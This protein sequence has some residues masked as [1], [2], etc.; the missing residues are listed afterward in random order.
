[1]AHDGEDS[2]ESVQ[3][4]GGDAQATSG[5]AQANAICIGV[6]ARLCTFTELFTDAEAR[7]GDCNHD[8]QQS[9]TS[10]ACNVAV[11]LSGG[12]FGPFVTEHGYLRGNGRGQGGHNGCETD[13]DRNL[14]VRCC[15]DQAPTDDCTCTADQS[16]CRDGAGGDTNPYVRDVVVTGDCSTELEISE[17]ESV[18]IVGAAVTTNGQCW[19]HS[20]P[21]ALNVYDMSLGAVSNSVGNTVLFKNTDRR[22]ELLPNM[23]RQPANEGRARWSWPY[24]ASV[25]QDF[26]RRYANPAGSQGRAEWNSAGY[27]ILVGRLGD[28]VTFSKLPPLFQTAELAELV[29]AVVVGGGDYDGSEACGSPGEVANDATLGHNY[30]SRNVDA[31]SYAYQN[32]MAS[33]RIQHVAEGSYA[34]Y[35]M[36]VGAEDQLRQ[37][38][39]WALS[40]QFVISGDSFAGT[41]VLD[42]EHWVTYYDIF[43]RHAFGNLRDILREVSF[44]PMM[45]SYLTFK[46][47]GSY[48]STGTWPDENYAREFMQLFSIGLYQLNSD[49]TRKQDADGNDLETYTNNDIMNFAR[50]WTGFKGPRTRPNLEGRAS[51]DGGSL[52]DP[53]VMVASSR[54]LMPKTDVKNGY[55]GDLVPVCA[56]R[57]DKAFLRTGAKYVYR[58]WS[59]TICKGYAGYNGPVGFGCAAAGLS[60]GRQNV[61]DFG[62]IDLAPAGSLYQRLCQPDESGDCTFPSEIVLDVNVECSGLEC[63]IEDVQQV[64]VATE[65]EAVFTSTSR[66]RAST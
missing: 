4:F 5:W 31:S 17:G 13:V 49:G 18:S 55:I 19:Q 21:N 11:S 42:E 58:G 12:R 8:G 61:G 56:D 53:M 38:V 1:M 40:Q 50:A 34:W 45:G 24:T 26:S 25:W 43:V 51:A 33:R 60:K 23:I 52:K 27:H 39:A 36:A 10:T 6:G 63:T 46:N 62:H 14:A 3:C 2:L 64:R 35:N 15:A 47:S 28:E 29:G 48:Y 57:P 66:R 22:N 7:G 44:S 59:E 41:H 65:T 9:W 20:H 30:N 54:D 32:V 16:S 37:K